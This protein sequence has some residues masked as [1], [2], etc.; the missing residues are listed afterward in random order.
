MLLFLLA[1]QSSKNGVDS[2]IQETQDTEVSTEDTA[3]SSNENEEGACFSNPPT[4]P[5]VVY[6]TPYDDDGNQVNLWHLQSSNGSLSTF[7]MGRATSGQI[8]VSPDGSWG[9]VAQT[10]GTI[11][12]FQYMDGTISVIES[13]FTPRVIG[14][15]V[16]ASD[17]W[18][19]AER[20]QL[21][22]TDVNW[23]NN[24]GGLFRATIDCET[25]AISDTER[26][27]SSKNGYGVRPIGDNWVYLSREV[28][29]QPYQLSIFA[30][31]YDAILARGMAFDDDESIF[32]ALASD[33]R[34]I[35][36]GDNNEF[37]TTPTR[38]S[39]SVWDGNVL[40]KLHEFEVNDPVSMVIVGD[41]AL[42]SSG[43][44]NELLQYQVSRQ[45][46]SSVVGLPLPS[47]IV[48]QGNHLYV[49]ANTALHKLEA[50]SAGFV[51]V[52]DVI[53][54]DG[55]DG[56]MGAVGVFGEF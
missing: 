53:S 56:I 8:Q 22:I 5:Y 52:G 33:G 40:S 17:V 54:L 36:V 46:L 10:D 45:S 28:E 15:D 2:G 12:I 26:V 18:L 39:H 11:G 14:Q 6:S 41:W 38:V 13:A 42:I 3:E 9:V 1:C 35:L 16:Y 55:L 49:P 29:E 51:S 19:D 7:E 37:S 25:G 34:N 23:P 48:H 43:Y 31:E 30:D 21:W 44:G 27:F 20:G 24:G 47:T 50:T 4:E 32:S